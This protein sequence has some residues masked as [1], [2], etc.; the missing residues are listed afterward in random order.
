[1]SQTGCNSWQFYKKTSNF[2][3]WHPTRLCYITTIIFT[4]DCTA[5]MLNSTLIKFVVDIT[6]IDLIINDD[7][8]NYHNEVEL[9]MKWSKDN[10]LMLDVDKTKEMTVDGPRGGSCAAWRVGGEAGRAPSGGL[11][12]CACSRTGWGR[13]HHTTTNDCRF[14]E[15]Q[16]F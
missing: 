14:H 13:H 16:K 4:H 6:V 10:N 1:M 5:H 7:N 9:L 3:Y 2:K 12:S 11:R 15:V 8:N